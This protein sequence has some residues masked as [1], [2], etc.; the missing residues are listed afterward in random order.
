MYGFLRFLA[1]TLVRGYFRCT[2]KGME[3]IPR[4]GPLILAA[5]K[6]GFR[7]ITTGN[8]PELVGHA[9]ADEYYYADFSDKDEVLTLAREQR[10]DA[11]CACANDFGAI[12]AAY[13]AE[14]MG[15]PGH[16]A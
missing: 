8:A 7:V 9:Y 10:I 5:K 3:N 2:G 14:E 1:R 11:I 13:V 16:D 12:T 15:L 4:S 6:L